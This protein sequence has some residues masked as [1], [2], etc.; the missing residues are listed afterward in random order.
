AGTAGLAAAGVLPDPVTFSSPTL[1]E[2]PDGDGIWAFDVNNPGVVVG[3]IGAL[4]D[5]T[6][7][8]P[9]RAF[10]WSPQKGFID[11]NPPGNPR[12]FSRAR[13]INDCG[14]IVGDVTLGNFG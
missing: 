8:Q 4:P 7:D 13:A 9:R 14:E 3:V 12:T 1:I 11:L 10:L 2:A 5:S 6:I